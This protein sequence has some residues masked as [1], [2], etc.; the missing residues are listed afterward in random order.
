MLAIRAARARKVNPFCVRRHVF[1]SRLQLPAGS[2][3]H[4]CRYRPAAVAGSDEERERAFACAFRE[5]DARIKIFTSLRLDALDELVLK[6][7]IE[8]IGKTRSD[9]EVGRTEH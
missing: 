2:A 4:Q 6:R 7:Q 8:A 9:T 5:L 1:T 3:L